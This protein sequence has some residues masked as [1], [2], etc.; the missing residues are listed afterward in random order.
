MVARRTEKAQQLRVLQVGGRLTLLLLLAL[1][2]LSP[3]LCFQAHGDQNQTSRARHLALLNGTAPP[4]GLREDSERSWEYGS[5]GTLLRE[6]KTQASHL[7][8]ETQLG[9]NQGPDKGT[10]PGLR[11]CRLP[12]LER[13]LARSWKV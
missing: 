7:A 12:S 6:R 10:G 11:P 8:P 1:G 9:R 5:L 2:P 3:A 13:K 4:R